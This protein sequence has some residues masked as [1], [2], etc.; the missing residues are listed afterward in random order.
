MNLGKILVHLILKIILG[1]FLHASNDG[2][3]LT[4]KYLINIQNLF[5][6]F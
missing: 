3:F 4:F 5:V 2:L 6:K 1:K